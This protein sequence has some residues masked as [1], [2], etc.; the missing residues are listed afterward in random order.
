ML[1]NSKNSHSACPELP[2]DVSRNCVNDAFDNIRNIVFEPKAISVAEA[3]VKTGS[4]RVDMNLDSSKWYKWKSGIQAPCYCNCRHLN[5]YPEERV[6]ITDALSE[7]IKHS[8][9][10]ID[11]VIGVA[12]AGVSWARVVADELELPFAY[13]RSSP[14]VHGVGG[15]VECSP[16]P[17]MKA[18]I[19]DDLVASGGS[20]KQ[21][22]SALSSE[23]SIQVRGIQSIVNWGFSSMRKNLEDF[24]V[25]TLT[26]FPW[27]LTIALVNGYINEYD[28]TELMAFYK[29]PRGHKWSRT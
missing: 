3:L 22:I 9:S 15:L 11:I 14:K 13:V 5:C 26:S 2:A 1:L 19:V 18:V 10:D 17:G 25:R 28:F 27:I 12:T 20:L 24:Q 16:L 6:L 7:S 4:Y 8:F 29:N 23:A 21:V